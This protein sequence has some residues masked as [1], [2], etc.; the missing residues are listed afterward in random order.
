M[1]HKELI[2]R[3]ALRAASLVRAES[4]TKEEKHTLLDSMQNT[5]LDNINKD[6]S[7]LVNEA[8]TFKYDIDNIFISYR[9]IINTLHNY[10]S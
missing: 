2:H 5:L 9:V 1:N 10:V 4:L 6:S 3:A 8:L 7:L